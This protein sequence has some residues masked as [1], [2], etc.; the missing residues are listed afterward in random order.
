MRSP[1]KSPGPRL[2]RLNNFLTEVFKFVAVKISPLTSE[3]EPRCFCSPVCPARLVA[4]LEVGTAEYIRFLNVS[5]R[6]ELYRV[7]A[8]VCG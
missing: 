8:N 1:G 5:R 2:F 6:R 3:E 4:Q 7:I